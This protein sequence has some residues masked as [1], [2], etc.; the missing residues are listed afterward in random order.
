MV[1]KLF[2]SQRGLNEVF[3]GGLGSYSIVCLAVSFLQMHPKLRGGEIDADKNMGVLLMEFFELYGFY[4]NYDEVGISLRDGGTYYNKQQR[5]W[6]ENATY[7]LSIED[8]ADPSESSCHFNFCQRQID[9]VWER[10]R[11]QR[12]LQGLLRNCK[13]SHNPGR[14]IRYPVSDDVPSCWRPGSTTRRPSFQAET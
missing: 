8:P 7:R 5:G 4:F 9:D 3:S 13:G 11:S 12:Y 6:L 1:T 14:C 2:L 10:L